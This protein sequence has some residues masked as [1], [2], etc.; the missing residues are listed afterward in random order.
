[1]SRSCAGQGE[2]AATLAWIASLGA[3]TAGA[4][5]GHERRSAASARA[6]LLAAERERMVVRARPLRGRPSLYALTRRGLRASGCGGLAPV[7]VGPAGAAHRIACAEV[8]VALERAYPDHRLGGEPELRLREREHG[9]PLAS[10]TLGG[11]AAPRTHRPDLVLWPARLQLAAPLAV[12][13][14]LSLKGP[15][16]L[17]EICRSWAR[18]ERVAGVLYVAAPHVLPVLALAIERA[19]AGGRVAVVELGA[20]V[21]APPADSAPAR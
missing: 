15:G 7:R 1:M 14:E 2:R 16:R 17:A 21:G 9:G 13:V 5:A 11:G 19:G 10:A 20:P 8:A 3:V 18:C 4:L 12:E 6:L